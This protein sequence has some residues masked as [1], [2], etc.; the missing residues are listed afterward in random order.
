MDLEDIPTGDLIAAARDRLTPTDTRIAEAVMADETLLAFGTVSD[1]ADRVGTSRPS[2]VRFAHRLGFDGYTEL[3]RYVRS[4]LTQRLARPSVRIRHDDPTLTAARLGLEDA[5]ASVFEAT[6]GDEMAALSRPIVNAETVWIVSGE[7]SRAGAY[8]FY[9]GISI[10]R[11]RVHFVQGHTM[12]TDLSS[13]GTNDAAVVFDFSRYRTEAFKAARI[14]SDL[15]VAIVAITDG[16]LSPLVSLTD[17]WCEIRIPGVGPFDSSVP[18]VAI[19]ELLVARV[20]ADLHNEATDRIDRIED[21][22]ESS[23]T[24]L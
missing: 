15:G 23:G 1:L 20:A 9:S 21:L 13:A 6:S 16:P 5:I 22:W 3:Q 11:P 10:V 24:F 17:T 2:I 19:A 14:L 7:T 18:A 12:G 4:G 8:A